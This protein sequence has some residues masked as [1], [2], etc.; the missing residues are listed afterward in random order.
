MMKLINN[1][2]RKVSFSEGGFS[3]DLIFLGFS[4]CCTSLLTKFFPA[5]LRETVELTDK[6]NSSWIYSYYK[7]TYHLHKHYVHGFIYIRL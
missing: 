3:L 6:L 4:H 1:L 2:I 7:L 5:T